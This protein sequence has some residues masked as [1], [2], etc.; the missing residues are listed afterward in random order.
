LA[1]RVV[2]SLLVATLLLVI[3][4][5]GVSAKLDST[6]SPARAQPGDIVTLTTGPNSEGVSQGGQAVP[7][8]LLAGTSSG[9][10]WNCVPNF[11]DAASA[12]V[13]GATLLGSLSWDHAT[14]V[15][16]LAFRVPGV[17]PGSHAIA[18]LAPNASPGCWP[19]ATLTVVAATPPATDTVESA[20]APNMSWLLIEAA[21]GVGALVGALWLPHRRSAP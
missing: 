21:A 19:E 5:A 8:Y 13:A 14:G 11:W 7:V 10:N 6:L 18:V 2:G 17:S 4:A 20:P 12:K 3:T 1:Y 9:A 16:T 15:G